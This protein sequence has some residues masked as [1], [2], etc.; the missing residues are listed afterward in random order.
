[1]R[2]FANGV[3]AYRL[4]L[5]R[6]SAEK[7]IKLGAKRLKWRDIAEKRI[8]LVRVAVHLEALTKSAETAL[9]DTPE[10]SVIAETCF[11]EW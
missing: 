9:H 7:R 6:H 8:D 10:H 2:E 3:S 5:S 4:N 11:G 1:M